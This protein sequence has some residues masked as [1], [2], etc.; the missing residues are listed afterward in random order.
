MIVK[1]EVDGELV[2]RWERK[3][4]IDVATALWDAAIARAKQMSGQVV[5]ELIVDVALPEPRPPAEGE[6]GAG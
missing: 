4:E 6:C 1:V 5:D 2:F 3:D